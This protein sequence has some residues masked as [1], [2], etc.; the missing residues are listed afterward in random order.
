MKLFHQCSTILEMKKFNFAGIGHILAF[1]TI[2]LFL[3]CLIITLKA[4]HIFAFPLPRLVSLCI[5]VFLTVIWVNFYT[6]TIRY[7]FTRIRKNELATTGPYALCQHPLYASFIFFLIP[8]GAFLFNSWLLFVPSIVM[9]ILFRILIPKEY[10]TLEEK[11][12][13]KWKE[14]HAKTPEIFPLNIKELKKMLT[15]SPS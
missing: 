1:V 15:K 11:Y 5:G 4:P 7:I 14:Y 10:K 9:F 2:P 12:G 3:L 6:R 13:E 8:G